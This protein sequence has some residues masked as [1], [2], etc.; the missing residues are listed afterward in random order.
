MRWY[1]VAEG[2]RIPRK[3]G[4]PHSKN[5][6]PLMKIPKELFHGLGRKDEATARSS[7]YQN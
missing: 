5:T 2:K 1:S 6:D 7:A 4:L 3:K